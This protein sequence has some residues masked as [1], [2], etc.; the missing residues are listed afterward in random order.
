[1][2]K[3]KTIAFAGLVCLSPT[4]TMAMGCQGGAHQAAMS[5]AEGSIWDA[6][7][8]RCVTDITG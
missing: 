2:T 3:L 5:C 8:R 4:L 7:A 1:M 6:D